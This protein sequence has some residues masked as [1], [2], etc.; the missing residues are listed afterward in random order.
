MNDTTALRRKPEISISASDHIRLMGLADAI[1]ERDASL[2][3]DLFGELERAKVVADGEITEGVIRMGSRVSFK[4]DKG[5]ERSVTLVF[6]PEADFA[7]GKLSILTPVGAAL[8]GLS[9]GQ[10]I[11]WTARDGQRHE[12]TVLAV[13]QDETQPA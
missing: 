7:L 12:L 6:P 9:A 5:V 13:S 10:S 2:A 3:D 4:D 11:L 8:I 1:S